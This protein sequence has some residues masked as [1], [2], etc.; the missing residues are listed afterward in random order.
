MVLLSGNRH[1]YAE[2][3]APSLKGDASADHEW[4]APHVAFD[5]SLYA[6]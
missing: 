4:T 5:S 3:G 2:S 6:L 1:L